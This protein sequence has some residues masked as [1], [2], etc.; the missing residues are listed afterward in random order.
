MPGRLVDHEHV[1]VLVDDV[2]AIG[3][4]VERPRRRRRDLDLDALAA[5]ESVRG[6]ADGAVHANEAAVDQRLEPRAREIGQARAQPA[7]E[8][9]APGRPRGSTGDGTRPS[10]VASTAAA[11][12]GSEPLDRCRR[13]SA[14]SVTPTVMAESATLK[15]G[16]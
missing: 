16:Q 13:R 5:A 1:V 8:S 2:S 14:R 12:G 11:S 4:G 9:L 15:A 7:I 10:A 3:S 6:L